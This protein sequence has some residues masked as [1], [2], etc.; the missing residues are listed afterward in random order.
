M[1]LSLASHLQKVLRSHLVVCALGEAW[2]PGSPTC[3][4]EDVMR[5]RRKLL[6]PRQR[7]RGLQMELSKELDP[8]PSPLGKV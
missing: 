6:D 3:S 5:G 4:H 8:F 7:H 1:E 2:G